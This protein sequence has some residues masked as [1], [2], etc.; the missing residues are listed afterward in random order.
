MDASETL[1]D[2]HLAENGARA[3]CQITHPTQ[4]KHHY[5]IEKIKIQNT[6]L[7]ESRWDDTGRGL[8]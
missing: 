5:F 4:Y 3:P 1:A 7:N 2:R 6:E 8:L